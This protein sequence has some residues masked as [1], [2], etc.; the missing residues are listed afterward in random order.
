MNDIFISIASYRD[1][2]LIDTINSAINNA[3]KPERIHFGIVYQGTEKEKPNLSNLKNV[4]MISMHPRDAR[5]AGFARNKAMTL[6]KGEKYF[7]QIDSHTQ[8][9]QEW[10]KKCI[11]QLD[12]AQKITKNKVILSSFALPYNRNNIGGQI[13]IQKQNKENI[14]TYPSKQKVIWK[15][16]SYWASER[17]EF[18]NPKNEVPEESN[19]VLGG[20]IFTYGSIVKDVPYDPDISFFGEEI[21]FSARAWTNG[22]DI[23][24]PKIPIVYH[25]YKRDGYNKVWNDTSVRE[26]TWREIENISQAKQKMVLCGLESGIYSLGNNRP[27]SEYE[28]MIGF[29]FKEHYNLLDKNIIK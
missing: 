8:F 15:K 7:L 5:G 25:F 18:D 19:V 4:S 11:E 9:V 1:P 16:G 23:Y 22:Y 20:F 6:Y 17:V 21:C 27:I 3:Q 26:I 2:D 10:D 12:L 24:S 13:N 28:N 29:S 14:K